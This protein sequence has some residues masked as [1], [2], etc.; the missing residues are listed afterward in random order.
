MTPFGLFLEKIRRSRQLQQKR[1]AAELGI[2]ASYVSS[3]EKG[4]KPP[5]SQKI[6]E[7]LIDVLDLDENEQA[8]MW[9]SVRQSKRTLEL[10]EGMVLAEYQ[11]VSMLSEKL[12]SLSEEQITVI[13]CVLALNFNKTKQLNPRRLNM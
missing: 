2:Q 5:P 1:L 10:P 8:G 11:L 13:K 9:E 4:R 12:G 3:L 6:L 7:K